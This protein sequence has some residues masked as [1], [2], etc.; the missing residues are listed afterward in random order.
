[1]VNP[2]VP[3]PS[4]GQMGSP[5]RALT[6]ASCWKS[7][8]HSTELNTELGRKLEVGAQIPFPD[9]QSMLPESR[10]ELLACRDHST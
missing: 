7:G 2:L 9:V 8:S 5:S 6:S 3:A 1:M 10:L 4:P